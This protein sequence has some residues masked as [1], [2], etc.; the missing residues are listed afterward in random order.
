VRVYYFMLTRKQIVG[1]F[2]IKTKTIIIM[3]ILVR[4]HFLDTDTYLDKK[5][6]IP[7]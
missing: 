6:E 1:A 2:G 5:N 4:V 7:F 3:H